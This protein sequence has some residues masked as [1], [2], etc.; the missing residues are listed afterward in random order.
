MYH[1]TTAGESSFANGLWEGSSVTDKLYTDA[2]QAT[3]E[4]GIPVPNKEN[5]EN[6]EG[7]VICLVLWAA[8]LNHC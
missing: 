2:A 1:Y 4:L 7:Q 8:R 5:S 3:Q 6:T